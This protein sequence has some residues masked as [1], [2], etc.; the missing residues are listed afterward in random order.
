MTAEKFLK[1]GLIRDQSANDGR[2]RAKNI[3]HCPK[4]PCVQKQLPFNVEEENFSR[5]GS[6]GLRVKIF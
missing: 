2:R 1:K 4:K 5:K 3:V 6:S